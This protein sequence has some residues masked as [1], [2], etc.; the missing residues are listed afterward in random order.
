MRNALHIQR[1]KFIF[2]DEGDEPLMWD[3]TG[4]VVSDKVEENYEPENARF[5]WRSNDTLVKPLWRIISG[6]NRWFSVITQCEEHFC[7]LYNKV[8]LQNF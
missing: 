1:V 2:S 7:F 6:T 3:N 5:D 8:S 4:S